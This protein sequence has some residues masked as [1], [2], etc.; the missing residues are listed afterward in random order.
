MKTA[1]SIGMSRI[2]TFI[3]GGT[4]VLNVGLNVALIPLVGIVGAAIATVMSYGLYTAAN[5]YIVS[6]EL[7]LRPAYLLGQVIT[8]MAITAV[9][10]GVVYSLLTYITG[11]VT[12]F[13]V[14]GAG[15]LIWIALSVAAGLLEPEKIA[16]TL[17]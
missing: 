17:S 5:L 6:L 2:A 8:I 10:S 14:V 4:A 9:M 1:A 11:W 15:G 3:R 13:L 7:E 12:L 16:S